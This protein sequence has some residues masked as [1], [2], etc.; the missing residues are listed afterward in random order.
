MNNVLQLGDH[1]RAVRALVRGGPRT[2]AGRS[3]MVQT[4]MARF[5]SVPCHTRLYTAQSA[6]WRTAGRIARLG[7]AEIH[8]H[9]R[10]AYHDCP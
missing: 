3:P 6:C 10:P 8:I 2:V 9:V 7:L 4:G 5:V 1:Q